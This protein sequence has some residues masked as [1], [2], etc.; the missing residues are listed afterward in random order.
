MFDDWASEFGIHDYPI[1]ATDVETVW[2]K[3]DITGFEGDC[4]LVRI[5]RQHQ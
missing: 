1:M 5:Y 4:D 3:C 2:G